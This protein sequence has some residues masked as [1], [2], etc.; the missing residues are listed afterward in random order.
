MNVY[1]GTIIVPRSKSRLYL[2]STTKQKKYSIEFAVVD[3]H[4]AP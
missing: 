4:A 2:R 3:E 1:N